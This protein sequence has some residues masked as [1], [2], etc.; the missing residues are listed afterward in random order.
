MASKKTTSKKATKPV[1]QQA[2]P[3]T[4]KIIDQK[5][6][7]AIGKIDST[8]GT[9]IEPQKEDVK[10]F[11]EGIVPGGFSKTYG[12]EVTNIEGGQMG[13]VIEA[14]A[15]I[16]KKEDGFRY[17][18]KYADNYIFT[19]MVPLKYSNESESY[20]EMYR[21]HMTSAV[22]R[23][24]DIVAQVGNLAKRVSQYIKYQFNR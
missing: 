16:F 5:L 2:T 17:F 11:Y 4:V 6:A 23:Q 15:K 7:E 14:L 24:G 21:C 18:F 22:L 8:K 9:E 12:D 1:V 3:E 10:Y 20:L 13:P 19:V